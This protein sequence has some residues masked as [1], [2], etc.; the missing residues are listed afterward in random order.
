MI[1]SDVSLAKAIESKR[2]GISPLD[3]KSIQPCSIDLKLHPSYRRLNHLDILDLEAV[4]ENHTTLF[5]NEDAEPIFVAP[6]ECV[7]MSTFE[8][9]TLSEDLAAQVDGKSS[10]GRLFQSIHITAGWIDAG[11]SGQITLE[12]VNHTQFPVLYHPYMPV[13]QLVVQE[14]TSAAEKPYGDKGNYQ[15]QEGPVE[16]RYKTTR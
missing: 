11:F 8:V 15:F 7:L 13:A 4:P 3:P 1:L 12:V 16:S 2:L 10:L 6:G 9:V 5:P 14:M